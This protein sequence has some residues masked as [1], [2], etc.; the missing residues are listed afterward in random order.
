MKRRS[1]EEKA[2]Q[3]AVE[4]CRAYNRLGG[5]DEAVLQDIAFDNN[6]DPEALRAAFERR[7]TAP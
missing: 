4:D 5:L 3:E 1:N 6:V 2:M 7:E